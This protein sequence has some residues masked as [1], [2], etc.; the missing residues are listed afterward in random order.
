MPVNCVPGDA[1]GNPSFVP[2]A[3]VTTTMTLAPLVGALRLEDALIVVVQAVGVSKPGDEA[4][5]VIRGDGGVYRTH[6]R[7]GFRRRTGHF[8]MKTMMNESTITVPTVSSR[9]EFSA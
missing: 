2:A 9:P 7:A 3:G 5:V 1:D 8:Y 6:F 4:S